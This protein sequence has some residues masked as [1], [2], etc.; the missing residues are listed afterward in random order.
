MK[1]IKKLDATTIK[2]IA[3]VLMVA[4]HIHQMFIGFGAPLWLT[5]L[6]RPVFPLF[7]FT[8]AE[9]FYYTR[10]RKKYLLRL[11]YASWSM[12]ILSA[13]LQFV[14]PNDRVV[15]ANNAFSTF[16]I[17]GLYIVFWDN[18]IKGIQQ[19]NI[20]KIITSILLCFIPII[21]SLPTLLIVQYTTNLPLKAIRGLV[22]LSMLI[23]NILLVEGGIAMIVLGV[24]FY[25]LRK[26]RL[27]QVGV[28]L[29]LS[30]VVFLTGNHIQSLMAIAAIPMLLYNGE[31]G[32][33][34]KSFFY[35]FYPV[36]IFVLYISSTLLGRLY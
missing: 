30:T 9:G 31:K 28:L 19:K 34:M 6:G 1:S 23:P 14:L 24:A 4:D 12:T 7:L 5:Y 10:S 35:I 32:R 2:I 36:H 26:Y 22:I 3:V 15:L 17:T 29:L 13:I 18:F 11:L 27:A 25:I 16:F 20:F 33:G 21:S 8:A